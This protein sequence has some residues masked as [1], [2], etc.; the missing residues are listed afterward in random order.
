MYKL[1]FLKGSTFDF[2]LKEV[3]RVERV[4]NNNFS[5]ATSPFDSAE[6]SRLLNE[7]FEHYGRREP[8]QP[9]TDELVEVIAHLT[10]LGKSE[11]DAV[12]LVEDAFI[13]VFDEYISVDPD[14]LYT[15]GKLM[16]VV[17]SA[18]PVKVDAFGWNADGMIEQYV[19]AHP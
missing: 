14:D 4:E 10:L 16:I 6:G 11:R 8:R 9:V 18:L 7:F 19:H 15:S 13:A 5:M 2:R 17:W 12:R 1:P 3:R